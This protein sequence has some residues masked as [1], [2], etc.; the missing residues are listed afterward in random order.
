MVD[1]RATNLLKYYKRY[2]ICEEISKG[3]VECNEYEQGR[4]S[5][6]MRMPMGLPNSI[7]RAKFV[8]QVQVPITFAVSVMKSIV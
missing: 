8:A 5:H 2:T 6:V 4:M 7:E 3:A 1:S